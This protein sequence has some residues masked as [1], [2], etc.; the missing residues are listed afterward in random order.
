MTEGK[1]FSEDDKGFYRLIE[2]HT[3]CDCERMWCHGG[4]DCRHPYTFPST[5]EYI[6]VKAE[7]CDECSS[8]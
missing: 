7:K 4:D 3:V 5:K 1:V 2:G 6:D 8:D